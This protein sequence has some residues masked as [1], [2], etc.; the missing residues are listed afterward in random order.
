MAKQA[1]KAASKAASAR[2]VTLEDNVGVRVVRIAEVFQRLAKQRVEARWGLRSTDLRILNILDGAESIAISE[3]AR[4]THVDKAWVSRSLRQLI[5]KGLVERHADA[6]DSRVVLA[7]LTR[8]G[9][10]LLEDI[11]PH[12]VWHERRV[13]KG[14]EARAFKRDLD[15]LLEN[16]EA[17][18][19]ERK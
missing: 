4:R 9:R 12:A 10:D 19:A 15:R 14:I 6:A 11:R 13:L 18:L 5:D 8:K 3:I 1:A 2:A 16:A 7:V 17:I